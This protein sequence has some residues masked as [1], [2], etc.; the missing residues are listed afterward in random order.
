[1]FY[2]PAK[3]NHGL[4]HDP[5]K[6]IVAPRPIGW[7]STLSSDGIAN[8][9]PYSFF[10][11]IGSRP[12]MVMFASEGEKDSLRNI[13]QT[14]E[15]VV[16]HVSLQLAQAMNASSAT[17]PFG[18]DEFVLAGVEKAACNL[19]R[20]PRVARAY[21]ALECRATK[22]EAVAG[23]D[24]TNTGSILVIGEVIGIHL[25]PAVIQNGFF[26]PLLASPV[27]RMGYKQ[28]QGPDG[29]FEMERPIDTK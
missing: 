15:F 19:V 13:R 23:L 12:P 3:R 8:L 9:S 1:M 17:V 10:N 27:A 11:A 18:V 5:F 25:D 20:P 7:I 26:D 2:E 22:V 28:Y 24:G 14:G 29:I 16:N 4:P 6:A 21:A